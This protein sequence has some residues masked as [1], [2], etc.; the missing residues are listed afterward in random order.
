MLQAVIRHHGREAGGGKWE[1]GGI[2]LHEGAV[3]AIR[4]V[5]V[6]ADCEGACARRGEAAFIAAEIEHASA[7]RQI[8]QNLVQAPAAIIV[9]N[10]PTPLA[11]CNLGML[12][13]P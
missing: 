11:R 12:C 1:A 10:V 9:E 3:T 13:C 5:A 8:S 6:Q 2:T 4:H 7:L